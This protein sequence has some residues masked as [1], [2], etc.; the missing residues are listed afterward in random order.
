MN[1]KKVI[2]LI[3]G[4]LVLLII[5]FLS[6][7]FFK[8]NNLNDNKKGSTALVDSKPEFLSTAEKTKLGIPTDTKIQAITRDE[9]GEITVYKII[10]NDS[11]ITNISDLK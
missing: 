3:S 4:V 1:N 6:M 2:M 11:D 10:H 8:G 9:N 7:S 5:V